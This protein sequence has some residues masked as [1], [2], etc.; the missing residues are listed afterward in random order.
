MLIAIKGETDSNTVIV[1]TFQPT[2]TNGQIT[3]TENT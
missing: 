1:E 3:Q 2:Y